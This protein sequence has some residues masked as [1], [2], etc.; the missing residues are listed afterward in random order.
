MRRKRPTKNI[1][2]KERVGERENIYVEKEKLG[3]ISWE[4]RLGGDLRHICEGCRM[5]L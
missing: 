4:E 5:Y 2:G 1:G 3:W